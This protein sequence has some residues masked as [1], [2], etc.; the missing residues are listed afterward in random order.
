MLCCPSTKNFAVDR[1]DYERTHSIKYSSRSL[2]RFLSDPV[3]AGERLSTN[4]V[5]HIS[6]P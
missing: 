6:G 5:R 4:I 2:H 1:K 3:N